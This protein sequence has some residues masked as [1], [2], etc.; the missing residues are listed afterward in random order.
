MV[1]LCGPIASLTSEAGTLICFARHRRNSA[2]PERGEHVI[3]PPDERVRL[4]ARGW[5]ELGRKAEG[6]ADDERRVEHLDPGRGGY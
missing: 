5:A 3:K 2:R 4:L 1:V 6:E